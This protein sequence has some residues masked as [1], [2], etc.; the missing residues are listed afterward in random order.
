MA[1]SRLKDLVENCY[2]DGQFTIA[3]FRKVPA[4]ATTAG[5]WS[6]LTMA[7]GNPKPNY[8][9]GTEKTATVFDSVSGLWHGG[10]VSPAEKYLHKLTMIANGSANQ[11]GTYI[12]C[13]FLLFY[14]LVDMDST[15]EQTLTNVTTLPR[16]TDGVGV[17]AFLVATNP[18]IGGQQVY[19]N[20]TDTSGVAGNQSAIHTTN[21]GATIG[22]IVNCGTT[23]A[24]N[25]GP[26]IR[27]ANGHTGLRSVESVTFLGPN[28]GLASLVLCRPLVTIQINEISAA[29]EF[30]FL[31]DHPSLPQIYDGAVLGFIFQPSGS[32]ASVAYN[33]TITTV[34]N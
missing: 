8:Y 14:P 31:I 13:D 22:Q 17:R 34:F 19:I 11:A 4:V 27:L 18:F 20:Y 23:G 9:V 1:L 5:I 21:T 3:G 29:V 6:D 24:F 26:F 32:V 16:Y 12:I 15:D 25:Y 33:G 2:E 30:D 28:G 7:P 10:N